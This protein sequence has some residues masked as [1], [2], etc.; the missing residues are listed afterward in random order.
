MQFINKEKPGI[1]VGDG[2]TLFVE[3]LLLADIKL[4]KLFACNVNILSLPLKDR[5]C[6]VDSVPSPA[7]MPSKRKMEELKIVIGIEP[8]TKK[9][10]SEVKFNRKTGKPFISPSKAFK[11][12][13][14]ECFPYLYPMRHVLEGKK[15]LNIQAV[16]Y[17]RTRRR[18]DLNN[19]HNALHDILVHYEVIDDDNSE[20]I[21]AT[22]GSRVKFDKDF[23]RTEITITQVQEVKNES[24][25]K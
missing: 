13:Q 4:Y 23:P 5:C 10:N 25:N 6:D 18:V 16:Y 24:E 7:D 1:S 8:R 14:A 22:D 15:G 2:T 11:E 21:A 9:N 3:M 20:V 19:L 12:Y 17:M